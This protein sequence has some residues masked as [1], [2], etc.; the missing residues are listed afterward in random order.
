M[1]YVVRATYPGY[2]R[3]T[4]IET[5]SPYVAQAWAD[6]CWSDGYKAVRITT[7]EEA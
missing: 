7:R 1:L 2:E 6:L 4:I 5:P 3:E